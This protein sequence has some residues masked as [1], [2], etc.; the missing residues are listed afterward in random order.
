MQLL[1]LILHFSQ[2]T[3]YVARVYSF[4]CYNLQI[5]LCIIKVFNFLS[6]RK[7][8]KLGCCYR[9]R[10]AVLI[11]STSIILLYIL[12]HIRVPF[13]E[14]YGQLSWSLPVGDPFHPPIFTWTS[15]K[16][17]AVTL[18]NV[19][20]F[21]L[22]H[23]PST[24][25]LVHEHGEDLSRSLTLLMCNHLSEK[26]QNRQHCRYLA[27]S[28]NCQLRGQ[29]PAGHWSE[30]QR[31]QYHTQERAGEPK[32]GGKHSWWRRCSQYPLLSH[33]IFHYILRT[34]LL[35]GGSFN[36]DKQKEMS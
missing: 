11:P 27:V 34:Q 26:S 13:F 3:T 7:K 9:S 35:G 10:P 5:T 30:M 2:V 15:R 20:S 4:T 19:V 21:L 14:E 22:D 18:V 28:Q 12:L 6:Y 24:A 23:H 8:K 29:I 16:S 1:T 32:E 33:Q 36:N 31:H 25:H 17:Q